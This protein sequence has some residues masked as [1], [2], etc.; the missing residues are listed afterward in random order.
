MSS[1]SKRVLESLIRSG[2]KTGARNHDAV[3]ES[4]PKQDAVTWVKP[5]KTGHSHSGKSAAKL[6]IP[7]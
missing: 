1:L 5:A 2:K 3:S 7:R 4:T 6:C